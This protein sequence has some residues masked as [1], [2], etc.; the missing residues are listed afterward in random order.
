M[1]NRPRPAKDQPRAGARAGQELDK[2]AE[3][4][5]KGVAASDAL[6]QLSLASNTVTSSFRMHKL[7]Y[8]LQSLIS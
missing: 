2:R 4:A 3:K 1:K 7:P 5:A 8:P 6:R